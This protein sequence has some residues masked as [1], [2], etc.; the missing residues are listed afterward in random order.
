MAPLPNR[1]LAITVV[2]DLSDIGREPDLSWGGQS[3]IGIVPTSARLLLSSRCVHHVR[4]CLLE[5]SPVWCADRVVHTHPHGR[6]HRKARERGRAEPPC[7]LRFNPVRAR[8][9]RVLRCGGDGVEAQRQLLVNGA[10]GV[11]KDMSGVA[12]DTG[13]PRRAL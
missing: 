6:M 13:E 11:Q 10:V 2:C 3:R 9:R 4:P 7:P 12:V 8:L 1:R 5:M